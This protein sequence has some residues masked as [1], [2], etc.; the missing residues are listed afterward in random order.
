LV[1]HKYIGVY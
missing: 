1:I